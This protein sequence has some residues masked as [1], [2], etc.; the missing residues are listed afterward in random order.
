MP[1][2]LQ[3]P[4]GLA[5]RVATTDR[6]AL[7]GYGG[8]AVVDLGTGTARDLIGG[9]RFGNLIYYANQA[10][11][12]VDFAAKRFVVDAHGITMRH[13]IIGGAATS[14]PESTDGSLV[15][16]DRWRRGR[17]VLLPLHG[18]VF[19]ARC[20][21]IC[22][23]RAGARGECAALSR[24]LARTPCHRLGWRWNRGYRGGN[25]EGR[26][27][28]FKNI[29]TNEELAFANGVPVQAAA[30]TFTCRPATA[31]AFKA[32]GRH[33]GGIQALRLSTGTVTACPIS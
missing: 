6:E 3:E 17:S 26:V 20:A 18:K 7:Y 12:G 33:G 1:K 25:S 4:R 19:R 21:R 11:V 13:P 10:E 28:F 23:S 15:G 27:L 14:Y 29:G 31:E 9:T 22:G 16:S 24:L 8:F 5:R 30:V 2:L 32:P